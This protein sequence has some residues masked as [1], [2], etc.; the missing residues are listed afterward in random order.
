MLRPLEYEAKPEGW[1]RP[2]YNREHSRKMINGLIPVN[3]GNGA[4]PDA[5]K[6]DH[7]G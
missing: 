4:E 3:R 7:R 2:A 5:D 1:K 6:N